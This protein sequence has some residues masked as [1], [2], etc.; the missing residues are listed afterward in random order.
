MRGRVYAVGGDVHLDDVFVLH[1]VVLGGRRAGCREV[2]PGEDYDAVMGRPYAYL[3]LGANHSH[4]LDA[5][6]F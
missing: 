1:A 5:A 2:V 6:D 4:G 3:I